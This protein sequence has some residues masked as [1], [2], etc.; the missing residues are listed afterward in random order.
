MEIIINIDK[1]SQEFRTLVAGECFYDGDE[2]FMKV[3]HY[4]AFNFNECEVR[5]YDEHD[6]VS[7]VRSKLLIG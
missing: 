2:L 5:D 1:V 4:S 6:I 3:N 7:W